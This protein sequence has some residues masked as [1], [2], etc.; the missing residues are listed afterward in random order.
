MKNQLLSLLSRLAVVAILCVAPV[1]A[2]SSLDQRLDNLA[3]QIA[4][5]LTENQKHTIAVVEFS[6]LKGQ[7]YRTSATEQN[8]R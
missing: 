1:S 5:D 4:N 8:H 2:Q 7:G 3:S 6:D